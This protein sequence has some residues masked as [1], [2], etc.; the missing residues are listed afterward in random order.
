MQSFT[1][2]RQSQWVSS[3]PK[4]KEPVP[5]TSNLWVTNYKAVVLVSTDSLERK[6]SS[7]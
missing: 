7:G 3:W 4:D 6:D 1:N 2:F 5:I